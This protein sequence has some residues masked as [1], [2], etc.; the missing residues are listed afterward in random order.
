M[1]KDENTEK[2]TAKWDPKAPLKRPLSALG[3]LMW[4]TSALNF[5]LA[6]ICAPLGSPVTPLVAPI[7]ASFFKLFSKTLLERPWAVFGRI[8][9]PFKLDF[10]V[11]L[12]V[13]WGPLEKWKLG[14]CVSGNI[15]FDYGGCPERYFFRI[16][17]RDQ[18]QIA[19]KFIFFENST[20]LGSI[21]GSPGIPI[22]PSFSSIFPTSS[23]GASGVDD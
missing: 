8:W 19:P 13:F 2:K 17:F 16:P 5:F 18:S 9:G 7:S 1:E 23:F 6:P 3:A 10:W 15:I 11:I 21:L 4:A 22:F 14:S 12:G 20:D